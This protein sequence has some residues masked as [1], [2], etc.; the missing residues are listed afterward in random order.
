MAEYHK[1]T[2]RN[3]K[4]YTEKGSQTEGNTLKLSK[5][6]EFTLS[7][8]DSVM[9]YQLDQT[10]I[11]TNYKEF[12][13]DV[14]PG[15]DYKISVHTLPDKHMST[16]KYV[17]QAF[18]FVFDD[19]NQLFK[20][21]AEEGNF[22]DPVKGLGIKRTFTF[23]SADKDKVKILV[24]SDNRELDKTLYTLML[25]FVTFR[26]KST[27]TGDFYITIEEIKEDEAVSRFS[28]AR[29]TERGAKG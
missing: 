24:F 22:N 2:G 21:S 16:N 28:N 20:L 19:E 25:N 13:A 9:V 14:V 3:A 23:N 11:I 10:K 27:T 17:F 4:R 1:L 6:H 7:P 8:D 5:K 29:S 15:K 26:Y 18:A 12:F